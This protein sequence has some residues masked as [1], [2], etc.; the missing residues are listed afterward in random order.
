MVTK[1]ETATT[2]TDCAHDETKEIQTRGFQAP[3]GPNENPAAHGGV[4][5]TVECVACGMRRAENHNAG[6]LEAGPWAGPTRAERIRSASAADVA[7]SQLRHRARE[8]RRQVG[9]LTL[10]IASDG[11]LLTDGPHTE[12]EALSA[13]HSWPAGLT[14]ATALRNAVLTAERAE[15]VR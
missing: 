2:R 1:D 12:E 14:A 10:T 3:L 15:E 6:Q 9:G 4:C 11:A 8:L 7:V 5:V 13:W